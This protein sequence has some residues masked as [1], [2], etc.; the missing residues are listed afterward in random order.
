MS[1]VSPEASLPAWSSQNPRSYFCA[2]SH[3]SNAI[4]ERS[5]RYAY[6]LR[7]VPRREWGGQEQGQLRPLMWTGPNSRREGKLLGGGRAICAR[8]CHGAC[9]CRATD[10]LW[11]GVLPKCIG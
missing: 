10:A 7:H 5:S 1:A 4:I 6:S 3:R 11:V 9:G 2:V 8:L